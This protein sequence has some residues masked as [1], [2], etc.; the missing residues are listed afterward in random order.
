MIILRSVTDGFN[1]LLGSMYTQVALIATHISYRVLN[2]KI[3]ISMVDSEYWNKVDKIASDLEW[4][5]FGLH[6]YLALQKF[7][8][9]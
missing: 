9:Q 8:Q 7:V 1:L 6:V 4:A 3:E 5:L 2:S